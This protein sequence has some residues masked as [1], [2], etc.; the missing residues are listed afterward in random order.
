MPPPEVVRGYNDA[1]ENGGERVFHQWETEADHR[2]R[3]NW[4]GQTFSFILA[5]SGRVC[6]LIFSLCFLGVAVYALSIKE[7]WVAAAGLTGSLAL[8]VGAFT[9]IPGLIKRI[10]DH[11]KPPQGK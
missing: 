11:R 4:R 1:V 10:Q 8:V 3:M 6:A 5:I 9:G 2:R 7:P